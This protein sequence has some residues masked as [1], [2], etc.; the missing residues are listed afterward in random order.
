[1]YLFQNWSNNHKVTGNIITSLRNYTQ[2]RYVI[3][4]SA[5]AI[6]VSA[7]AVFGQE[8]RT[9]LAGV[10][11]AICH[12]SPSINYGQ[13]T[14]VIVPQISAMLTVGSREKILT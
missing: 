10:P 13:K 5:N 12:R 3:I 11:T 4:S 8:G 9:D 14:S 2:E 6:S 7:H 1:V